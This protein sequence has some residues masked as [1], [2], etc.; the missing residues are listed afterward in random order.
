MQGICWERAGEG[1]KK[2]R[3]PHKSDAVEGDREGRHGSQEQKSQAAGR[4]VR[5]SQWANLEPKSPLEESCIMLQCPAMPSH[6]LVAACR[7]GGLSV[8]VGVGKR[9][10]QMG[11]LVYYTPVARE[12]SDSCLLII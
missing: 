11:P 7:E 6:R 12:S 2:L 5:P 10:Q 8:N 1:G 4:M 9:G 3:P